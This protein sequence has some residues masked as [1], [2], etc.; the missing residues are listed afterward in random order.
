MEKQKKTMK[1]PEKKLDLNEEQM[2]TVIMQSSNEKDL[3]NL[4]GNS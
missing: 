3:E 4:E 2:K 1:P